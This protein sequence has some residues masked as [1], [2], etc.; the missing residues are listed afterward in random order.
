VAWVLQRGRTRA[1]PQR[2]GCAALG[3]GGA[4]DIGRLRAL[5]PGRPGPGSPG[6]PA[7]GDLVL[8][9]D[10]RFVLPPE[11][12]LG[13]GRERGSDRLQRGGNVFLKVSMA[14]SFCAQFVLRPIR[15]APNSFCAV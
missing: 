4:K 12:Y 5:V 13:I 3:T 7:P 6:R 10:P 2:Q 15:F 8:L 1:A 14:N 9:A 11:L